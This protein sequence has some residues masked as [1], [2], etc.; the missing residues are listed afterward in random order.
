MPVVDVYVQTPYYFGYL[1][2]VEMISTAKWNPQANTSSEFTIEIVTSVAI[3]I[4]II[5]NMLTK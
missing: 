5:C 3:A 4:I 2:I 1:G